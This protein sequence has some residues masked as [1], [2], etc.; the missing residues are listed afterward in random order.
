MRVP[1]LLQSRVMEWWLHGED[2]RA[3]VELE[4]RRVHKAIF[5]VNDLAIRSLP[6]ALSLVGGSRTLMLATLISQEAT[7]F[8]S[9]PFAAALSVVLLAISLGLAYGFRRLLRVEGAVVHE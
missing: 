7:G 6:Y 5:C 2:V 1:Y 4:P 8:L 3:G 9:W